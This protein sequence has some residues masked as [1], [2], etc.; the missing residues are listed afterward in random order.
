MTNL[1]AVTAASTCLSLLFLWFL[2]H[3]AYRDYRVDLFRQRMFALRDELF[4]LAREGA[5]NFDHPAYGLLRTVLN[6]FLRFAHR[7]RPFT[8]AWIAWRADQ[9]TLR[10]AT[11]SFVKQ[12]GEATASLD[13]ETGKRLNDILLRA[14]LRVAD[15]L[16]L[17]SLALVLTI[18]PVILVFLAAV[19]QKHFADVLRAHFSRHLAQPVKDWWHAAVDR[20]DTTA[21]AVGAG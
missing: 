21:L 2:F 17:T 9:E 3:W 20:I 8:L 15:Q 6:G 13:E 18:V 12:W 10:L 19:V 16:V 7:M 4:D 1:T 11:E 14:H 5:I